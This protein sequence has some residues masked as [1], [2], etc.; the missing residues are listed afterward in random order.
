LMLL[1]S[2]LNSFLT[3]RCTPLALISSREC[4]A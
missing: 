2:M 1:L 4:F 3:P